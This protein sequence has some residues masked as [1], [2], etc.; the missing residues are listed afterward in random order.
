MFFVW[1]GIKNWP[2]ALSYKALCPEHA[3]RQTEKWQGTETPV[4]EIRAIANDQGSRQA[5][6]P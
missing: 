3:A 1:Y 4:V 6:R 2:T 5:V